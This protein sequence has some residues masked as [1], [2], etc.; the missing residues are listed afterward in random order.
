MAE[1]GGSETATV[2]IRFVNALVVIDENPFGGETIAGA[3]SNKIVQVG[4]VTDELGHG[5]PWVTNSPYEA[6]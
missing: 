1:L 3:N 6:T 4:V 5:G 2:A